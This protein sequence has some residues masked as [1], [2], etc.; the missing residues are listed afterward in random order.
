M[1]ARCGVAQIGPKPLTKVA[2]TLGV[3]LADLK[4]NNVGARIAGLIASSVLFFAG[5]LLI[6][7]ILLSLAGPVDAMFGRTVADGLWPSTL[8]FS[9]NE[10]WSIALPIAICMFLAVSRLVPREET[11][12]SEPDVDA[13]FVAVRQLLGVRTVEGLYF[14]PMHPGDS[15]S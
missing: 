6:A 1:R 12:A 3:T 2:Q 13:E 11:C 10:L 8:D 4:R 15:G 9:F 14:A 5:L 7:E